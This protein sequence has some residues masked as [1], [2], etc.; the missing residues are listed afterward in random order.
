MDESHDTRLMINGR[1]QG[2]GYRA[3]LAQEAQRR[4]LRGWVRNRA[5]GAV[6]A[7]LI[8]PKPAVEDMIAACHRGPAAARVERV[9]VLPP[10]DA[11]MDPGAATAFTVR[12]TL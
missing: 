5:S 7:R 8:G 3:W 12:P 6:E 1:V 4:G 9:E 10:G 11:A 2:V